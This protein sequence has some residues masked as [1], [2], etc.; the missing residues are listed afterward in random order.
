M[1]L[2]LLALETFST[3]SAWA[4]AVDKAVTSRRK[5]SLLARLLRSLLKIS[6]MERN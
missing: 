1:V 5:S 3:C 6:T 2:R 4:A